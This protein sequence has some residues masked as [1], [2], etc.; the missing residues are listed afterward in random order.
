MFL[1]MFVLL[2]V[3][4]PIQKS[5]NPKIQKSKVLQPISQETLDFWIFGFWDFG[6]LGFWDFGIFGFLD[7]WIFGFRD[8]DDFSYSRFS[9]FL[10]Y[11]RAAIHMYTCQNFKYV[12]TTQ[13]VTENPK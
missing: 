13:N 3:L 9:L 4:F 10:T 6:I 1:Q 5:K 12:Q 8:F 11:K 7:F 2:N